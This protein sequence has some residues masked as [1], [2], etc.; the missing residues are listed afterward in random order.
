VIC[1]AIDGLKAHDDRTLDLFLCRIV[2]ADVAA[3]HCRHHA[4]DLKLTVRCRARLNRL[5]N[6]RA[7]TCHKRDTPPD[8]SRKRR[9]R[10]RGLCYRLEPAPSTNF[11]AGAPAGIQR[12]RVPAACANSSIKLS[13]QKPCCELFTLRQ[14][15]RRIDRRHFTERIIWFG[16][17]GRSLRPV[18]A[19]REL[20]IIFAG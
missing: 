2:V 16:I 5:G 17:V 9:S 10:A 20:Q 7:K 15:P 8:A 3:I 6:D 12:D 19:L 11:G 1:S 14:E 18:G 13:V 4:T